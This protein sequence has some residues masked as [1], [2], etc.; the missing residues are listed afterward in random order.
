MRILQTLLFSILFVGACGPSFVIHAHD[1]YYELS[2]GSGDA[3]DYRATSASGIRLGVREFE[4]EGHGSQAFWEQ[5]IRNQLQFHAGYAITEETEIRAHSGETG[6]LFHC[7]KDE[8]SQTY[9]YWVAVFVADDQVFVV[10]AG[11]LRAQFEPDRTD[12]QAAFE[13][14]EI[15]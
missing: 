7:G 15:H 9:D 8:A 12:L 14:F 3:F 6:R 13:S 1:D 11:G 2:T 4:N 5:A 10:E